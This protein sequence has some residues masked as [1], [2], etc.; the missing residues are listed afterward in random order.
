MRH[1]TGSL[2]AALTSVSIRSTVV[3]PA[4]APV[5]TGESGAVALDVATIDDEAG[6]HTGELTIGGKCCCGRV[7]AASYLR[8]DSRGPWVVHTCRDTGRAVETDRV[9]R[10]QGG[11]L[12]NTRVGDRESVG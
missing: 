10:E 3:T 8:E 6:T 2:L 1:Q 9:A 4:A 12:T 7:C 5:D 11:F